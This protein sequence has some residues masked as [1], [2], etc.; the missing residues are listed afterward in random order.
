MKKLK[1]IGSVAAAS[2]IAIGGAAH[3]AEVTCG[4]SSLGIRLTAV[5]PGLT[6]GLCY[7]VAGNLDLQFSGTNPKFLTIGSDTLQLIGKNNDSATDALGTYTGNGANS[8]R[9]SVEADTWLTWTRVFLGFHFGN[10]HSGNDPDKL[11]AANPDSFVIELA[12]V[13]ISGDWELTGSPLS[14]NGEDLAL[15]GLSNMYVFGLGTDIP[16]ARTNTCGGGGGGG[17]TPVPEPGSLALAGLALLGLAATR[18]R[19]S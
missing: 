10:G 14:I 7:A 9:W 12:P 16:C 18:K 13:D 4:D 3:G 17:T 2:L 15:T 19:S 5:D 1:S 6:G 11:A 8:G